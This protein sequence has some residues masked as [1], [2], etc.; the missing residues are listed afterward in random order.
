[1]TRVI[2]LHDRAAQADNP[3]MNELRVSKAT[4]ALAGAVLFLLVL[5]TSVGV[6]AALKDSTAWSALPVGWVA[7]WVTALLSITGYLAWSESSSDSAAA[8]A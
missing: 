2:S 4:L 1:V 5:G 7:V 6:T 8:T 3:D